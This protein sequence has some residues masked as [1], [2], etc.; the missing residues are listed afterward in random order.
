[1][2]APDGLDPRIDSADGTDVVNAAEPERM[3][4]EEMVSLLGAMARQLVQDAPPTLRDASAVAAEVAA[5][6][7]RAA[8]PA[9]RVAAETTDDASVRLAELLEAYALSVREQQAA[10]AAQAVEPDTA[11]DPEGADEQEAL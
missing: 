8:G 1:M 4:G 7:A 9:A 5:S 6:A 3:T 11:P 10:E 2:D